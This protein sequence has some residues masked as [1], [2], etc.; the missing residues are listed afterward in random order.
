MISFA[1]QLAGLTPEVIAQ[2]A[3]AL[4]P[5][6]LTSMRKIMREGRGLLLRY[7]RAALR[8]R[9]GRTF[10]AIRAGQVSASLH[11]E[12]LNGRLTHRAFL[13]NIFDGG[14]QVPG[15][16]LRPRAKQ[17]LRFVDA[18]GVVRYSRGHTVS[19]FALPAKRI[20]PQMLEAIR[21]I[22][23]FRI[24]QVIR[25]VVAEGQSDAE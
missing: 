23:A 8:Q 9:S 17:A 13:L 6:L 16:D 14:A 10:A 22:A 20:T 5:A 4:R 18:G 12:F 11:G 25:R 7:A 3:D 21:P 24:P 2:R 15:G 1:A 19:G